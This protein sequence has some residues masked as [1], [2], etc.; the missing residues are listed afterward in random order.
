MR[1]AKQPV[2]SAYAIFTQTICEGLVPAWY[3]EGDYPVIYTTEREAQLEI[4]DDLRINLVQFLKGEREFDDAI[5]V[6]DFILP[7][8]VW[9]DGSISIE[10]GRTFGKRS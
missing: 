7:V 3:G 8:D 4:V 2:R 5:T 9:P 1:Q 6:D 10:D